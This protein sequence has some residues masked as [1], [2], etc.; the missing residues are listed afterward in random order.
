MEVT[1][2]LGCLPTGRYEAESLVGRGAGGRGG[3]SP[4]SYLCSLFL[5]ING[6][7]VVYKSALSLGNAFLPG[8]EVHPSRLQVSLLSVS[9][10]RGR[11]ARLARVFSTQQSAVLYR[12]TE[13]RLCSLVYSSS[14]TAWHGTARPTSMLTAGGS[15]LRVA[16]RALLDQGIPLPGL[17]A[18]RETSPASAQPW[19]SGGR[20][21]VADIT[22]SWIAAPARL[23][24]IK[25]AHVLTKMSLPKRGCA[26]F[27]VQH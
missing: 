10:D 9:V 15:A 21:G 26:P 11:T 4:S 20:R 7:Y 24:R 8:Q 13:Q 5:I 22:P 2:Q 6:R 25:V 14:P 17:H 12:S 19:L 23:S 3:T 18:S 1:S 16:C 27:Y